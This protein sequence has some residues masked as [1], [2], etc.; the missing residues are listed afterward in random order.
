MYLCLVIVNLRFYKISAYQKLLRTLSCI[1]IEWITNEI[2]FFIFNDYSIVLSLICSVPVSK[3]EHVSYE[4][5]GDRGG[6]Q[7]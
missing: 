7:K 3:Y 2:V 4:V 1:C 6:I 5:V